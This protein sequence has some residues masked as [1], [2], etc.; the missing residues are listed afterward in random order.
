MAQSSGTGATFTLSAFG[1]E[2]DADLDTQ[3]ELLTE[4]SIGYLELRSAWDTNVLKLD[5]AQ[6]AAIKDACKRHSVEVSCIGSP[7]GKSPILDPI[8]TEMENL[9]RIFQ[10]AK[11]LG[12]G[13]RTLYRKL[14]DYGLR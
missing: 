7:I 2:I 14:R 1:D 4:L 3:L 12:I 10:T 8:E 5:D 11:A 9:D 6:V 13:A